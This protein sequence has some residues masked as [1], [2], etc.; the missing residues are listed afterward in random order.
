MASG[1]GI[2][3]GEDPKRNSEG[4]I[5]VGDQLIKRNAAKNTTEWH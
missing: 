4:E 2:G 3:E 1:G 5:G